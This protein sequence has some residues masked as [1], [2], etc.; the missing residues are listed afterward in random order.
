MATIITRV[1]FTSK[2]NSLAAEQFNLLLYLQTAERAGAP[3]GS[4]PRDIFRQSYHRRVSLVS[5]QKCLRNNVIKGIKMG[6]DLTGWGGGVGGRGD[7]SRPLVLSCSVA[8]QD[9]A[10]GAGGPLIFQDEMR[11]KQ[12]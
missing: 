1:A 12:M 10:G 2:N 8:G 3:S 7:F 5:V 9:R 4:P 6:S 11:V